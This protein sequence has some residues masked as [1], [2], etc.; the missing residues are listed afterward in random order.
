MV[1]PSESEAYARAMR[2][3]GVWVEPLFG[4]AKQRHGL[5]QFRLRGLPKVTTEGLFVAAGQNLKRWLVT[6]GWGRRHAP[7]GVLAPPRHATRA[8]RLR[9]AC[10]GRERARPPHAGTLRARWPFGCSG[11]RKDGMMRRWRR[12]LGRWLAVLVVLAGTPGAV[13][14][15]EVLA[16]PAAQGAGT[17]RAAPD[18]R[19]GSRGAGS[20]RERRPP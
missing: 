16:A 4:E 13:R 8:R 14:Q 20:S 17:G 3:R 15:G 9:V 6:T 2:K 5:R 1:R 11:G 19:A 7:C 10:A 12:A 18:E